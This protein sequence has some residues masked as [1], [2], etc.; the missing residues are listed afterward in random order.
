MTIN[1]T[2]NTIMI[3]FV[4]GV[5]TGCKTS[6]GLTKE[7]LS[8]KIEEY[9]F[10]QMP[11]PTNA[12]NHTN[13]VSDA[14]I[15]ITYEMDFEDFQ[16]YAEDLYDYYFSLEDVKVIGY[17]ERMETMGFFTN[18]FI[19]ISDH[20]PLDTGPNIENNDIKYMFAFSTLDYEDN[21]AIDER[22]IVTLSYSPAYSVPGNNVTITLDKSTLT[23]VYINNAT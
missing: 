20:L 15:S 7:E 22:K 16:V 21:S 11:E 14:D 23:S 17:V 10:F 18:L 5:L 4:V 9:G 13:K 6:T 8:T 1:K 3:L 2:I 12:S 19:T